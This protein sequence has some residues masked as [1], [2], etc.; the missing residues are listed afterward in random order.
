MESGEFVKRVT[1]MEPKVKRYIYRYF[2]L[3][4]DG[5]RLR[6]EAEQEALT[7]AWAK[8]GQLRDLT[9]FD[10]WYMQIVV[11]VC[12]NLYK[13]ERRLWQHH[14]SLEQKQ[15]GGFDP[16]DPTTEVVPVLPM[17]D[18]IQEALYKVL[19]RDERSAVILHSVNHYSIL[20]TAQYL[21]K[22]VD[23]TR[24]LI[25]RALKKLRKYFKGLEQNS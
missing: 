13:K 10:A 3:Y 1:A 2:A 5:V 6:E 12:H 4:A 17:L 19:T 8:R 21:G 15:E 14:Q 20:E 22:S 11:R 23:A 24:N 9:L 25:Y 7:K 18:S 16:A